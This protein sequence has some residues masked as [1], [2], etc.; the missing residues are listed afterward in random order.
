MDLKELKQLISLM[1]ENELIELELEEEGKKVRLRKAA[2][3]AEHSGL[4]L[5]QGPI[6]VSPAGV[7]AVPEAGGHTQITRQVSNTREITSPMVGTFYL[8]PSPDSDNFVEI[9]DEITE[10]SVVCIIEAMKV[11]NEIKAEIDGEILD[12]LVENG[13][14]VEYGQALFIVKPA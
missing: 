12:I 14:A 13:E 10:E 8:A 9:G 4:P 5:V 6:V 1:N 2:P 3:V 11:M 7:G